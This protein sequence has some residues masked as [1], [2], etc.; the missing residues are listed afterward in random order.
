MPEDSIEQADAAEELGLA[1][2]QRHGTKPPE[3]VIPAQASVGPEEVLPEELDSENSAWLEKLMPK[4]LNLETK[5]KILSFFVNAGRVIS[6]AGEEAEEMI[7][8]FKK[9]IIETKGRV[10]LE[11]EETVESAKETIKWEIPKKTKEAKKK[12]KEF[13]VRIGSCLTV[14]ASLAVCCGAGALVVYGVR[15]AQEKRRLEESGV[16]VPAEQ[17]KQEIA[18]QQQQIYEADYLRYAKAGLPDEDG[19]IYQGLGVPGLDKTAHILNGDV[20]I[21]TAMRG[22]SW[23]FAMYPNEAGVLQTNDLLVEKIAGQLGVS[24]V[25]LKAEWPHLNADPAYALQY[26]QAHGANA[27]VTNFYQCTT[28]VYN[29]D[30]DKTT[31]QDRLPGVQACSVSSS[32]LEGREKLVKTEIYQ[33]DENFESAVE[34]VTTTTGTDFACIRGSMETLMVCGGNVGQAVE[35]VDSYAHR[36]DIHTSLAHDME[37]SMSAYAL[38]PLFLLRIGQHS[39]QGLKTRIKDWI[40]RG[41][42][43]KMTEILAKIG[44]ERWLGR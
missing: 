18:N 29:S 6:Q 7:K 16:D 37:I 10:K 28:D 27:T 43:R 38:L 11:V 30:L 1:R 17:Q 35:M 40:D 14:V 5:E 24:P 32:S 23:N 22:A 44:Q 3:S 19:D 12:T 39:V 13:G 20:Q 34:I 21:Q 33:P 41:E 36:P 31:W 26:L 15:Y 9:E 25:N 2:V 4:G 42:I 8:E